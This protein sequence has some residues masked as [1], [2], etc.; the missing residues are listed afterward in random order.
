MV[1]KHDGENVAWRIERDSRHLNRAAME[2]GQMETQETKVFIVYSW[3]SKRW[4]EK[5][6]RHGGLYVRF[7]NGSITLEDFNQIL[8]GVEDKIAKALNT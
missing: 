8:K 5:P 2:T 1:N 4:G 3:Q 7:P 6:Q